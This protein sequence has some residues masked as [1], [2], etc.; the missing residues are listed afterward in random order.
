MR[1]IAHWA[2][3]VR[4]PQ[5]DIH[6]ES[7]DIDS[8]V[9]RHPILG[10]PF[11][12]GVIVLGQSLAIGVRAMVV[13]A[14]QSLEEE[15]RLTSR[16][17]GISLAVAMVLFVGDLHPRAHDPVR[18]GGQPLRRRVGGARRR[19]GVPGG[20]LRRLPLAHRALQG[21]PARLPYHGAEHKTIAAYEHAEP[22]DPAHVDRFPKEHVRCGTNF[23]IIVMIVT[24]FVFTLFGTPGILWRLALARDRD[25][26]HRRDR[27]RGAAPR[28][29][30]PRRGPD[31]RPD[32]TRASG[33]RRSR[34]GSR[35]PSRSRWRSPP[36]TRSCAARRTPR[37]APARRESV[38]RGH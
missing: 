16:Q 35:T 24:I 34:R 13:A 29:A 6:V 28:R 30:L 11:L 31:A 1:G 7:H 4:R 20:A 12:R 38:R 27:V 32:A 23:L 8:V 36:S 18:V 10:K 3:A 5:G 21:R 33:S 2:V 26:H 9:G 17:V 37:G 22:L 19:G 15:D 25:P 14:N